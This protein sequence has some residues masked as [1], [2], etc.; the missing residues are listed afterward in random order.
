M[1]SSMKLVHAAR[2]A[3]LVLSLGAASGGAAVPAA[4]SDKTLVY[5]DNDFLGPGQSNIQAMI[6]LLRDPKVELLGVGVVT[7]DAWLQ[8]ETRHLLRFLEIA[9]RPDVPVAKGAEMPLLR[10]QG[11]MRA[12]EQRYGAIPWKGAWNA[13]RPG[14]SYHPD[15]PALVPP[16]PEGEP[17]IAAVPEDAAHLLISLVRA[18]PGEVTVITAGPL[19]DIALALRLAPDLPA[20]AKEIVIEGGGLDLAV[21]RV[22]GNT[23]YATDFN[24]LFDPEAAHIVLTAPWKK[25]TVMGNVTGSVKVTPELVGQVASA[26][27]PLARYFHDYAKVGQPLWDELTAAVAIDRSLVTEELVARM[28]VDLLPGPAYGTAQIWK[29]EFAPHQGE[30]TVH[31]VQKVDTT[32]FLSTFTAQARQ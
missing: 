24:F 20:L 27:T 8:E 14:R 31:I 4:A 18:H 12:W 28:D 1:G 25:I 32:R 17:Q 30:Q 13:P 22:T 19:T 10:T 16:L 9:G 11:E 15:D 29:D 2:A 7:G 26:G 3:A 21:A 6:P 5:F 23:D